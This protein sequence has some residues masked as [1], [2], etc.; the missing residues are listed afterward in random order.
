MNELLKNAR[1]FLNSAYLIYKNADYTSSTILYFKALFVILDYIILAKEGRSPKD[2]TERFRMLE[3]GFPQ[4]YTL[5]DKYYPI[6]RDTYSL[7]I[8]KEICD[9]VKKNVEGI[10]KEYKISF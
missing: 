9:E 2:H 6:Y 4:L 7:S 1:K 3:T 5:L 8:R 10:I